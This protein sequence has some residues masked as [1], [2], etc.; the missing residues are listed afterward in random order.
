MIELVNENGSVLVADLSSAFE[1]SEV[2]IRSDLSLLEQKG[3]LSR[4][5][6]GAARWT[7]K[8]VSGHEK[9]PG[10]LVLEE[11]Y[12]QASDP[13]KRIAQAEEGIMLL[14]SHVDT[15]LVISNDKLRHQFGNLK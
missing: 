7:A 5:H 14:K 10:E 3:A 13:K 2:T 8:D 11:R 4:F 15:L 9:Q 1:V 6:G 12:L